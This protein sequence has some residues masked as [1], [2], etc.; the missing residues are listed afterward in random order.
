MLVRNRVSRI[1][2]AKH[3]FDY[4]VSLK[5]ATI[6]NMGFATTMKA[7]FSYLHS[8]FRK[9]PEDN[10]ENFY[11]NRF[12]RVLYSMF[13][14]AIQRNFGADTLGKSRQIGERKE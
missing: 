9:L 11:I 6:K 7:G 8:V 3:F 14:K 2:Y 4:P 5:W 12:G 1:Y 10:L 13:L